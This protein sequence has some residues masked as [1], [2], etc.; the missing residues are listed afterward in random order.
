MVQAAVQL[1]KAK[2]AKKASKPAPAKSADPRASRSA[3]KMI[4]K[5]V[6]HKARMQALLKV[7]KHKK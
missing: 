6:A 1:K 3:S 2:A 5:E 4:K 7:K